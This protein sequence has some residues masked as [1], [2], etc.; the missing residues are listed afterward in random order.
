MDIFAHRAIFDGKEN[1]KYGIAKN[2]Q[3]GFG[4]EIDLRCDSRGV[5]LSHDY[6][7]LAEL[8]N[9]VCSLLKNSNSTIALH[10]KK[11]SCTM[12]I[13]KL[14][15][16][17]DIKNCFLFDSDYKF[18]LNK[19]ANFEVAFY[20]SSK[21]KKIDARILWCDEIKEKWYSQNLINKLHNENKI[22]YAVSR[23]LVTKSDLSEIFNDWKRL[24]DLGFDGI[25]T[26]HPV[27]LH[28]FL[29]NYD[30][31]TDDISVM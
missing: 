7:N 26:N 31:K 1:S 30:Y 17:F 29:T 16:N 2:L 6:P 4:I 9:S 11:L 15:E 27:E 5:Y 24:I 25:C 13:V 14:L 19:S 8:F 22:L 10:I 21:P 18:I 23:E 3:L 20:A 12:E 28:K